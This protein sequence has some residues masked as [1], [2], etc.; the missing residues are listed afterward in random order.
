LLLHVATTPQGKKIRLLS[1]PYFLAGRVEKYV[2]WLME[3][4]EERGVLNFII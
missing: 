1:L 4:K 2:V 3:K